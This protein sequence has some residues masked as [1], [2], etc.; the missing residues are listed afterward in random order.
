[1]F[2]ERYTLNLL[3]WL[4][5]LASSGAQLGTAYG[6]DPKVRSFGYQKHA[7]IVARFAPQELRIMRVFFKG[8]DWRQRTR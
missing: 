1:M 5:A 3:A 6:D 7:T 4:R 8:Q 2:A